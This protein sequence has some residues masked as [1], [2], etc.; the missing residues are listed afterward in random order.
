MNP[1]SSKAEKKKNNDD[2]KH[3]E[4]R[5][6]ILSAIGLSV[7]LGGTFL[8]TPNFPIVY[9]GIL[10]LI[11]ELTTK[12]IPEAKAKRVLKNLE[13]KEILTLEKRGDQVLVYLKGWNS[14][15]LK[16]SLRSLLDLKKKEKKWQGKWFLVIFDVPEIQRN[17]RNYLRSFLHYIG[18]YPYQQSVYVFPY[19]CEDEIVLVK[20]IVESAKYISYVVAEKIEF[21]D[22]AK[23]HF[24]LA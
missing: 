22:E 19:E 7:L 20:K 3:R 4:L 15:I 8:I 24:G 2:F 5:E 23:R 11:E 13:K 21:E 10:K 17:K 18:F 16:Y 6:I 9:S 14:T 1:S 12:K